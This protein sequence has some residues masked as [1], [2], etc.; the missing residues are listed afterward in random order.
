MN[1][2]HAWTV[3][4]E[5]LIE[6]AVLLRSSRE[7]VPPPQVVSAILRKALAA[8]MEELSGAQPLAQLIQNV[9]RTQSRGGKSS[10]TAL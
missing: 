2:S 1:A 3:D 8:E 10:G 4:S 6:Q 9:V 7:G 5:D